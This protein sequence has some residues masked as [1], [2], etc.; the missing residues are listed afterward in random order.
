[1]ATKISNIS[2]DLIIHPGET[3]GDILF[4]RGITQAELATRTGVTP[5]YVHNA[6]AGKREISD[7]FALALGNAL[8][9]S[10][11]FWINLQANYDAELLELNAHGTNTE[12]GALI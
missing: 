12:A 3:I 5:A 8:G 9:I 4:E 11:S 7:K 6:I 1:M 2:R 10:K